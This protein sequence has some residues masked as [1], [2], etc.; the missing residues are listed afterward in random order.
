MKIRKI[1]VWKAN[2]GLTRPYSIA[3]KSV[4]SVACCFVEVMAGDLSGLG[5]CNPSKQV[6]GE[7]VDDAI[8]VLSEENLEWLIGQDIRHINTLCNQ[9]MERFPENPGARAALDIA[10]YDI[11]SK[12]LGVPLVSF[13]G[14]STDQKLPTSITIG[15]KDV[16]GTLEEAEE[17]IG[18]GF[19]NL[20]VKLAGHSLDE[21]IERLSKLNEKYGKNVKIRIDP[22][23]SYSLNMLQDFYYKTIALDLEIIEQPLTV[24]DSLQ[25]R[26][27][28]ADIKKVIALDEALVS[29]YDAFTLATKPSAGGI[30]NIKLMK[31]GGVHQARD[32]ATIA[33]N[34]GISLMWGCNDESR[35]S[36][37]AALH[38][39]FAQPHT[40]YIDLDG[41]F[42]LAEDLVTGGFT[43]TNGMMQ[44][45]EKP[46]L[47]VE[48]IN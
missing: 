34:S 46:G 26:K 13:L 3:Y 4:D 7:D 39:A 35:V 5:S 21:D 47:G 42:D 31:C 30:F 9:L 1:N 27:L 44:V 28:P 11:F 8:A 14:G 38:A 2:L 40:R 20:K 41:S 33:K 19:T 32:I 36:I 10:L 37:A 24:E 12:H 15:I 18:K 16:Q 17:Y 45:T 29:P 48:R 22:N 23:Q 25:M 43:V 6:V